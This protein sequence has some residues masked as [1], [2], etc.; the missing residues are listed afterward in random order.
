MGE[1]FNEEEFA[2]RYKQRLAIVV[3]YRDRPYHLIQFMDR[4]KNYFQRD[5]LVMPMTFD[6]CITA[7]RRGKVQTAKEKTEVQKNKKCDALLAPPPFAP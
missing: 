2:A 1:L 5:K 3:P 7:D 4:I 6:T